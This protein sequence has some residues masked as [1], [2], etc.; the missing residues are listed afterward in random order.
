[1]SQY[2][3][4]IYT[5][6]VGIVIGAL[7]AWVK[8]LVSNKKKKQDL[9]NGLV[10]ALKEGMAILLRKEIRDYYGEYEHKDEIPLDEWEEIEAT[11]NVYKKL[12]GNHSG[13]RMFEE[14]K[15]KHLKGGK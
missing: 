7:V 3:M 11:H 13:D 5:T 14:M 10:D 4:P 1:M 6:L 15:S 8:N 12:D 2:F 9:E